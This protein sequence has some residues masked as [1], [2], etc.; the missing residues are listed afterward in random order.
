M[1]S[2][3][4]E[5]LDPDDW[6]DARA[7][8][9]RMVDDAI[10]HLSSLRDRPIWRQMPEETQERFRQGLPATPS[11]LKEVYDDFQSDVLNYA[12]GNTHPRFWG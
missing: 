4:E 3:N 6:S 9:H 7:L 10:D 1:S 5:T 12:M 8:A 2:D 11:P